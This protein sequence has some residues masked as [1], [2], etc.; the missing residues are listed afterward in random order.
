MIFLHHKITK[1]CSSGWETEQILQKKL[2]NVLAVVNDSKPQL[3]PQ[4]KSP[5]PPVKASLPSPS[6]SVIFALCLQNRL[7]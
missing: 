1:Y 5:H 6:H 2:T 4:K 7:L 3:Q